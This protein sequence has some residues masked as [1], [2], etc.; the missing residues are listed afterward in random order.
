MSKDEIRKIRERVENYNYHDRYY[1][2]MQ[3]LL[4][5]IDRL[6]EEDDGHHMLLQIQLKREMPFIEEWQKEND[7]PLTCPDYIG[8]IEH[9]RN[10]RNY[11]LAEIDRLGEENKML[12]HN[13]E[14][15]SGNEHGF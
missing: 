15:L 7:K 4:T 3:A 13:C 12:K 8:L 14:R 6:Q 5:E 2:D 11:A 9:Y 1:L 10:G